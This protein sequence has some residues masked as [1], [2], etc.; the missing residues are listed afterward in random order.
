[1]DTV[2]I[3]VADSARARILRCEGRTGR[4]L[5]DVEA[6]VRGEARQHDQD[7]VSDRPGRGWANAGGDGRHAMDPPTDPVAHERALFARTLAER[8]K[9]ALGERSFEHLVIVAEPSFLGTLRDALD[10]EVAKRIS[11]ELDSNIVRIEDL[12]A[13]RS[14]LPDFLY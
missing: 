2:W 4:R 8:L 5:H 11:V 13:L 14:H 6:L 9:Q 7:L 1:M 3:L 12:E 10:R